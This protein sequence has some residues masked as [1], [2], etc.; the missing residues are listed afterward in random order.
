[1]RHLNSLDYHRVRKMAPDK[2][3]ASVAFGMGLSIKQLSRPSNS[4]VHRIAAEANKKGARFAAAAV[5]FQAL[6][7][8]LTM[9]APVQATI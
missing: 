1:M 3:I 9:T 8:V 5:G 2:A 4:S 7:T 6:S